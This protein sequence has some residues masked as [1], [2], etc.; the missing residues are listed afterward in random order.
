VLAYE[1]GPGT[2]EQPPEHQGDEDG[3]VELPRERDE[4]RDEVERHGEIDEREHARRLPAPGHARVREQPLEEDPAVR[5]ETSDQPHVP[6]PAAHDDHH[7]QQRVDGEQRAE[8]DGQ[9][10]QGRF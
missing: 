2:P 7:Q 6:L 9:P 5:H 10:A 8:R 3:V 4:V 1:P